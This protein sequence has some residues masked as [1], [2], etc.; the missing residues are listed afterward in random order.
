MGSA[1]PCPWVVTL[2]QAPEIGEPL[3]GGKA[4]RLVRLR[5]SG[6]RAANGF[7]LTTAAYRQFVAHNALQRVI[8]LELGRKPLESM[9]W[10]EL[11][12]AAL[13]IRSM[14]LK[15]TIP[16]AL[17]AAI[18]DYHDTLGQEKNLAVRSSAPGEDSA[19]AS[20]A[21]I[22]ESILDVAG[23]DDLL[24]AVRVVWA[25]LWSDAAL[26]YRRELGLDPL[27]S[28]MAVLVQDMVEGEVSGVA[29]GRDPVDPTGGGAR[30][31]QP[32]GGWSCRPGSLGAA[33]LYRRGFQVPAR[34]EAGFPSR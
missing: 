30:S 2:D 33:P 3:L 32:A 34:A 12:D 22:H 13:R 18:G 14:F 29:F 23:S 1:A 10:E 8:A 7:C 19:R 5:Q 25:S 4:W 20:F 24:N 16:S 6:F 27:K 21:G 26:L 31:L 28:S 9:R 15:A 11:W 17:V